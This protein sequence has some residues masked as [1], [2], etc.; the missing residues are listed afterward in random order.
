M[1]AGQSIAAARYITPHRDTLT[2]P[3]SSSLT[4]PFPVTRDK[5]TVHVALATAVYLPLTLTAA[6]W[7]HTR[8]TYNTGWRCGGLAA[9]VY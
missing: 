5:V 2:L 3:A 7:R 1:Q 6:V 9:V 8:L 4:P